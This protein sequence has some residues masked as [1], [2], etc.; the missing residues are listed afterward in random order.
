MFEL[1]GIMGF[2]VCQEKDCFRFA[3]GEYDVFVDPYLTKNN[4]GD[5]DYLPIPIQNVDVV[6]KTTQ[7]L[8]IVPSNNGM[9]LNFFEVDTSKLP[10]TEAVFLPQYCII[11]YTYLVQENGRLFRDF[12]LSYPAIYSKDM[13]AIIGEFSL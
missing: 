5:W 10:N 4:K 12:L 1:G 8:M 6:E 9:E 2:V 7:D 11:H 3:M 13:K